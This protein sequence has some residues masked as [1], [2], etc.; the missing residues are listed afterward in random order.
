MGSW[1]SEERRPWRV[2]GSWCGNPVSPVVGHPAESCHV[3][4]RDPGCPFSR[5]P[6]LLPW[7]NE[8]QCFL[9]PEPGVPP[10]AP[11]QGKEHSGGR[12]GQAGSP[13]RPS[14]VLALQPCFACSRFQATFRWLQSSPETP[15]C[16]DLDPHAHLFLRGSLAL[17][18]DAGAVV[19]VG[20]PGARR[21]WPGPP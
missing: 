7:K 5:C 16:S 13:A 11:E 20:Q 18:G 17:P 6:V 15:G 14:P 3:L 1:G 2:S 21:V 8:T 19:G 10:C 4:S 9:L 12:W